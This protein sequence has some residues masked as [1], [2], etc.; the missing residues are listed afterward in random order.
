MKNKNDKLSERKDDSNSTSMDIE[1]KIIS[2]M[3]LYFTES[4]LVLI[5]NGNIVDVGLRMQILQAALQTTQADYE[6]LYRTDEN[7]FLLC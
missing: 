7:G 5:D 3:T 1:D 2:A 4:G 6:N